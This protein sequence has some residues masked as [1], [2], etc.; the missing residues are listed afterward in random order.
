MKKFDQNLIF[1]MYNKF[2]W[3]F[4]ETTEFSFSGFLMHFETKTI[5]KDFAVIKSILLD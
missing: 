2:L 5:S 3:E 4:S 1:L